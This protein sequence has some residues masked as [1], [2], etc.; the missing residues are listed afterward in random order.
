VIGTPAHEALAQHFRA[1]LAVRP[2][3]LS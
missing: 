1:A 3:G 2:A